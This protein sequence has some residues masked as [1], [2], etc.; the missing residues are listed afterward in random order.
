MN[1][2]L[3][4]KAIV[5]V[6]ARIMLIYKQL[7]RSVN[8]LSQS[9]QQSLIQPIRSWYQANKLNQELVSWNGGINGMSTG[10]PAHSLL[11]R[12]LSIHPVRLDCTRLSPTGACSPRLVI[13]LFIW[14]PLNYGTIFPFLLEIYLQL[15]FLRRLLKLIY[16]KRR[17]PAN[18]LFSFFSQRRTCIQDF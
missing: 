13:D 18:L 9:C 15:M 10:S 6:L 11:T 3:L 7:S 2:A 4:A 16:F 5:D 17:F 12:P 1:C 8:Y 14:R